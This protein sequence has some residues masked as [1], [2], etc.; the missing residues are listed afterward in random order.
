MELAAEGQRMSWGKLQ[1]GDAQHSLVPGKAGARTLSQTGASDNL[2]DIAI[3]SAI[4]R[5]KLEFSFGW[6]GLEKLALI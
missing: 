6:N 5:L 2:V 1:A 3:A 4:A